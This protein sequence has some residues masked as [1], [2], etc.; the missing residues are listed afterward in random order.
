MDWTKQADEV[1]KTVAST[2][3]RIWES[4]IESIQ[5]M[6]SPQTPGAWEKTVETWRGAVKKALD[7]QVELTRL[8]TEG[9]SEGMNTAGAPAGMTDWT[10]QMLEMTK[11]LTDTQVRFSE[12][13]FDMMKNT[14]P[15]AIT[16]AWDADSAKKILQTWQEAAQ[17]AM[18][19]Q[20]D[21]SRMF[22]PKSEGEKK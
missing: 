7:S 9:L 5:T 6:S 8:W 22:A 13:W 16:K 3:Q 15:M 20:A 11:N 19:A 4:L 18:E 1:I 14:D 10:R 12:S 2:Q 17:K 21:W